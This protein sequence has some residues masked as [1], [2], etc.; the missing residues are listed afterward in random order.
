[1]VPAPVNPGHVLALV[2]MEPRTLSIVRPHV[3][4]AADARRATL[5]LARYVE[6]EVIEEVEP[7]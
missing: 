2:A 6:A 3:Q 5:R 4:E 7:K 1:M